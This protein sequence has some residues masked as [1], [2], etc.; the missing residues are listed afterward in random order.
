MNGLHDWRTRSIVVKRL[1]GPAPN[2]SADC[3]L[4]NLER[5]IAC[6]ATDIGSMHA[7]MSTLGEICLWIDVLDGTTYEGYYRGVCAHISSPQQCIQQGH[8]PSHQYP[9]TH[10]SN[11]LEWKVKNR[12]TIVLKSRQ[13]FLL[14]DPHEWHDPHPNIG[15]LQHGLIM[16]LCIQYWI[17]YTVTCWPTGH[18]PSSTSGPCSATVPENLKGVWRSNEGNEMTLTHVLKLWEEIRPWLDRVP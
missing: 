4:T 15:S 11:N 12:H 6:H 8:R 2:T 17:T 7:P 18:S 10:F 16:I 3:P 5:L 14:P 13:V 1:T 9:F